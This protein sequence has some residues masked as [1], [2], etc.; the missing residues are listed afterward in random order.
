MERLTLPATL[1]ALPRIASYVKAV[2]ADAGLD[3]KAT[4]RLRQAVDEVAT[5]IILHGYEEAGLSGDID[6]DA[7][8]EDSRLVVVLEDS[9][10]PYDPRTQPPPDDLDRPPEERQI[11]GLGVY[12][13]II[14]LDDFAYE[15]VGG[16]NR[17]VF[18]MSRPAAR[19]TPGGPR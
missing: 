6:I 8:L 1:D 19:V 3:K 11:G 12:L 13:T 2:A 18:I 4:Y 5:N 7:R 17:N 9:A 16:R 15:H 10:L 14:D